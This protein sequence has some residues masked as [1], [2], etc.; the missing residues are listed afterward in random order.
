MTLLEPAVSLTDL[1]LAIE[2]TLFAIFLARGA[3]SERGPRR[4]WILFFASLALASLLGFVTHGFFADKSLPLYRLLWGA[5]LLSIGC[6]ALAATAVAALLIFEMRTA[7]RIVWSATSL[8]VPYSMAV[9]AGS[10]HFGLAVAAYTPAMVFLLAAFVRQFRKT[11]ARYWLLG[12]SGLVLTA[13]A[14]ILQQLGVGLHPVHFNHNALYHV[15]QALALW[16]LY[17][18]AHASLKTPI[19]G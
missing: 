17:L 15:I 8:L 1:G 11:S 19:H 2:T 18:S 16:M 12:I 14:A 10:H 13:I 7:M 3:S 6:M 9:L 4:W 5:T